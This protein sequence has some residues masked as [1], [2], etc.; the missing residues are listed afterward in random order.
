ML[1]LGNGFKMIIKCNFFAFIG[2]GFCY[3]WQWENHKSREIAH[4]IK[5][6]EDLRGFPLQNQLTRYLNHYHSKLYN[7]RKVMKCT[8]RQN[9]FVLAWSNYKPNEAR[10]LQMNDLYLSELIGN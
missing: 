2:R 6:T 3:Q 7:N 4:T 5:E 8:I 9:Y 1:S 10:K